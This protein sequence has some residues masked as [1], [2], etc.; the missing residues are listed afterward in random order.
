MRQPKTRGDKRRRRKNGEWQRRIVTRDPAAAAR[1]AVYKVVPP[2][3]SARARPVCAPGHAEACGPARATTHGVMLQCRRAGC[4][5]LVWWRR[6][7]AV[8]YATGRHTVAAGAGCPNPRHDTRR[9]RA[10]AGGVAR[11]K[12]QQAEM[13]QQLER[14]ERCLVDWPETPDD[15]DMW[16][17]PREAERRVAREVLEKAGRDGS[18]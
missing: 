6:A 5:A 2:T 18:W 13:A 17:R 3:S 7:K 4:G 9:K 1:Q 15:A 10:T 8:A 14:G 12:T 11:F 16:R